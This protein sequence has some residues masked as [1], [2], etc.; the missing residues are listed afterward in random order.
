[1]DGVA[2]MKTEKRILE[3]QRE[4]NRIKWKTAPL[5]IGRPGYMGDA[6]DRLESQWDQSCGCYGWRL[7]WEWGEQV[8]PQHLAL[9]IYEDAYLEHLRKSP[10]TLDWLIKTAKDVYDTAKSNVHARFDYDY[11]ETKG[12]HYHDIAVRRAVIRLGKKFQGDY[13]VHIRWVD[14]EGFRLNPG[15]VPFHMPEMIYQGEVINASG[16]NSWWDKGTIEDF[17]QRNKLL[18]HK[19][20]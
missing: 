15:K 11:Q 6:R 3:E 13:L 10:E 17:W 16:K 19:D 8:L 7:A 9:Q 18:Q 1:M 12:N 4:Y 2:K 20:F 14:S 5:P